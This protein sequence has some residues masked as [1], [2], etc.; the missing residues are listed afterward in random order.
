MEIVKFVYC[1]KE[2]YF[3]EHLIFTG[4]TDFNEEK[5]DEVF[6]K[7][8]HNK[9]SYDLKEYWDLSDKEL[10]DKMIIKEL[11]K[12]ITFPKFDNEHS[13]QIKFNGKTIKNPTIISIRWSGYI[14]EY[15]IKNIGHEYDYQPESKLEKIF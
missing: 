2:Y 9:N 1:N 15:R 7:F 14:W 12:P 13:F 11:S 5:R 10:L 4:T 8:I 3:K 6:I